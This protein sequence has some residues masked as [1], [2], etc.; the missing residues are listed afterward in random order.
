MAILHNPESNFTKEMAKWEQLPSEYT[1]GG[2]K[3]GNPYK[4]RPFPA[5][6]YQARQQPGS[7]KWATTMDVPSQFGFRDVS[8]WD[9]A[10]QEAARFNESCQRTVMDADE[11]KRATDEG[12]RPTPGEAMAFRD[13][14][15]KAISEAAAE[16]NW[17]DRNVSEKAKEEVAVAEAS[18]FGH[19]AEI[20]EKPKARRGKRIA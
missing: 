17:R 20:P 7:G 3:P 12:W 11:A 5:M 9:R 15:E 19:L 13:S 1:I 8:E 16:R 6:M 18:N 10:C 4:F 14:L 2:L